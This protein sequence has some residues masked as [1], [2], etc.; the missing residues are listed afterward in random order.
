MKE[1]TREVH[2][3][4]WSFMGHPDWPRAGMQESNECQAALGKRVLHLERGYQEHSG[5][6]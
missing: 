3:R 6:D 2:G 1:E 4:R 5:S